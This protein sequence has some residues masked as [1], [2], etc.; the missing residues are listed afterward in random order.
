VFEGLTEIR[1]QGYF[2]RDG[3]VS[4]RGRLRGLAEAAHKLSTR[5][6]ADASRSGSLLLF[7]N[8]L[9]LGAWLYTGLLSFFRCCN[10]GMPGVPW[11]GWYLNK[12]SLAGMDRGEFL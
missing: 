4:E 11:L 3:E 1:S 10:R 8:S 5:L 12:G 9:L 2:L 6:T 7:R